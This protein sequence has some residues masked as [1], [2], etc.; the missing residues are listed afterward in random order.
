MQTIFQLPKAFDEDAHRFKQET[1][2]APGR[3]YRQMRIQLARQLLA[4]GLNV[5]E[6]SEH[7]G[8]DNPFHF[9]RLFRQIE[10]I[11]PQQFR[12]QHWQPPLRGG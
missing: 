11:P 4:S 5:K 10:G 6:T 7:L 1:G 8:F 2:V 3:A 9:S 12:R